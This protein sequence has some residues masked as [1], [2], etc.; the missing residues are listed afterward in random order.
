MQRQFSVSPNLHIRPFARILR[1]GVSVAVRLDACVRY[2]SPPVAACVFQAHLVAPSCVLAGVMEPRVRAAADVCALLGHHSARP[3][4]RD[5]GE[6][7]PGT[8]VRRR[9]T[10]LGTSGAKLPPR[11][12]G[13]KC[14]RSFSAAMGHAV[15]S[16]HAGMHVSYSV[17]PCF[18]RRLD[19][20]ND[21]LQASMS[22]CR[23]HNI[24]NLCRKLLLVTAGGSSVPCR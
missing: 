16:W 21:S 23:V 15:P 18:L 4:A 24:L 19:T 9:S 7:V 22:R 6:E 20:P 5:P 10:R 3:E 11:S 8:A 12:Q 2:P 14:L 13:R 17:S 1:Q